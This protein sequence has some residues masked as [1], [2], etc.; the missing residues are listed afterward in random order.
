MS[1]PFAETRFRRLFAAQVVALVGTGLLTVALS[2]AAFDIAGSD[3]GA[4]LGTA[5]AIKMVAYVGLSPVVAAVTA[6]LS[7]K[8]V[9]VSADVIRAG[10]AVVLPFVDHAWQIYVLVFILQAAS[11]TFTPAFQSTI[12][13]VLPGDRAYTKAVSM[14]RLAYDLESI[15]SPLVAAALLT[16][17][18]YHVL[19]AGTAV[20]FLVSM[21]LVARTDLSDVT[22]TESASFRSRVT[23]GVRTFGLHPG[24]RG[25]AAVN[26]VVA[27]VTSVVVVDSVVFARDMLGGADGAVAMLLLG[28][29]TGSISVAI[30]LP[31]LLN[32]IEDRT[33]MLAGCAFA[34]LV[35]VLFTVLA[36]VA[37]SGGAGWLCAGA[38]WVSAGVAASAMGTPSARVV[39]RHARKAELSPLFTAQFSLSHACFLLTYPIAGWVG[40]TWGLPLSIG[41]LA[42]LATLGTIAALL[43]WRS[44][45]GGGDGGVDSDSFAEPGAFVGAGPRSGR[46]RQ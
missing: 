16:V 15:V 10:V 25:L 2:L 39:R 29:G 17:L 24:L 4:V 26:M 44:N 31:R 7:R 14:S 23:S 35:L 6:R 9:L 36:L 41:L 12:P 43:L 3:A 11:A 1:S 45:E 42:A 21:I 38:L 32:R 22:T 19:F 27:A 33:V 40:A 34:C 46:V 13:A 30:G 20:G 18:S 5:L 8:A 28:F 37:P